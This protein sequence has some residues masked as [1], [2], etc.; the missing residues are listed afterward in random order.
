M[1]INVNSLLYKGYIEEIENKK[2]M[3]RITKLDPVMQRMPENLMRQVTEFQKEFSHP[4]TDFTNTL[5]EMAEM[6]RV[7]G[8][9]VTSFNR[10]SRGMKVS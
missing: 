1:S 2:K 7:C 6:L 10:S 4:N 5:E 3:Y 8:Y 9:N